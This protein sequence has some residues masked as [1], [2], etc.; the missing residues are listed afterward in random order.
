MTGPTLKNIGEDAA[1]RYLQ[2]LG[3]RVVERN[4]RT[5]FGEI[6]IVAMEGCRLIFAEVKTRRPG[7][8]SSP[9]E[10]VGYRKQQQLRR[11]AESYI[12]IRRPAFKDCRFDVL[13]VTESHGDLEILHIEDAF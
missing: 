10:A 8:T 11:L 4:F 5:R 7:Q 6:D 2:R 9:I 12:A 13:G 1:A 3:I